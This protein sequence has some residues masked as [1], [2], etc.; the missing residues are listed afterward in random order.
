MRHEALR[1]QLD[2][3]FTERRLTQVQRHERHFGVY[4]D[5]VTQPFPAVLENHQLRALDI[6]LQQVELIDVEVVETMGL[7]LHF[8]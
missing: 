1:P 3:H 4:R 6:D 7:N 8:L 5:S 2:V